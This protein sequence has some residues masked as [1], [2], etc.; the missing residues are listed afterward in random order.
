MNTKFFLHL[1]PDW[2]LIKG[3]WSDCIRFF[4][5]LSEMGLEESSYFFPLP[6]VNFT[7][8]KLYCLEDLNENV[9]SCDGNRKDYTQLGIGSCTNLFLYPNS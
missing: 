2:E 8:E 9:T 1:Q 7:A 6:Q 5:K 4:F 3:F